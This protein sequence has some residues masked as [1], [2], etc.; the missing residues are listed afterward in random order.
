MGR[1][2]RKLRK[3]QAKD[4]EERLSGKVGLFNLLPES[5][6]SCSKEF[7]K[8]DKAM[9]SMWRVAVREQ[10][11]EVLLYCPACWEKGVNQ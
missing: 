6:L 8:T 11:K 10:E 2:S 4:A 5:C 7:D 1:T 9:V 3:K